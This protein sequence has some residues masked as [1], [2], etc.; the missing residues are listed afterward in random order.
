MDVVHT[1]VEL[2][3]TAR[4]EGVLAL[5][6]RAIYTDD[7]FIKKGLMLIVDGTDPAL[8]DK[9][10]T[11]IAQPK[12]KNKCDKIRAR[13]RAQAK[14]IKHLVETVNRQSARITKLTN[15][16]DRYKGEQPQE[17][18]DGDNPE[19]ERTFIFEDFLA[20]PNRDLQI[21]MREVD[22]ADLSIALK[23]A[24]EALQAH[25]LANLSMRL[26]QFTME[27]MT[28]TEVRMTDIEEAQQKI[29]HIARRLQDCGEIRGDLS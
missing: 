4:R 21:I 10:R 6:E 7:L 15:D 17:P 29:I 3:N 27:S 26:G 19:S 12:W 11:R 5:E 20:F 24:S 18:Q 8:E 2:A 14:E 16:L 9:P 13:S 28:L 1:I 25:F 22:Q 23:G